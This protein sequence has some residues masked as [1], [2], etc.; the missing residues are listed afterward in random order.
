M[1]LYAAGLRMTD[2]WPLSIVEHGVGLNITM[3]SYNGALGVGFTAAKCAVEDADEL[4]ADFVSAFTQLKKAIA[5][6]DGVAAPKK[7]AVKR[8]AGAA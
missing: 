2:Y 3:M 7:R 4:V 1:P 8:G 5:E 6:R